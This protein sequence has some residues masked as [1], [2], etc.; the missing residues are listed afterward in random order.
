[1]VATAS[2]G[3]RS[4]SFVRDPLASGWWFR[5][6]GSPQVV[7]G[8]TDRHI[9]YAQM[10]QPSPWATTT[11][12]AE[13]IHGTSLAFIS[14]VGQTPQVVAG[15]DALVTNLPGLALLVRTA[16]CLPLFFADPVR[17]VVGIAHAGW[18]GL[19][20]LLPVKVVA[21][22]QH[23]YHTQPDALAVAI[24]PAIRS[25]CYEVGP[26]FAARFGPF[27]Q[28]RHA[29]RTCDLVA[30]AL[31]QLQQCGVRADRIIDSQ[32]CTGCEPQYWYSLRREGPSTG[33]LVSFIMLRAS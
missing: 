12:E 25:C 19:A 6:W 29:R 23:G 31:D 20:G 9:E 16:D 28:E 27:V 10:L 7:A 22:L 8:I 11:V 26:E 32:H 3:K 2:V 4:A 15:C 33:R 5:Q 1:M 18:R 30:L 24:G 14:R 17:G 21:A 13:Q